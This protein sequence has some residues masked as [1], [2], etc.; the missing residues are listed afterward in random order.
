MNKISNESP[1][2]RQI[3]ITII[4]YLILVAGAIAMLLPFWWMIISSFKSSVELFKMPPTWFPQNFTLENYKKV[5]ELIPFLSYLKNSLAVGIVTTLVGMFTSSLLGYIFAKYEFPGKNIIF[6]SILV[7]LIVPYQMLMIP[8]FKIMLSFGWLDTYKVLTIPYFYNIFGIFLMRQFMRDVPNELME[9]AE[10]DGCS[11]FGTF[12]K[13]VI[14][15]VTPA[16]AT[17]SI[18]L[19]MASWDSF[20]WPLIAINSESLMTLPIG[21]N[22]F[23]TSHGGNYGYLMAASLMTIIPMVL[24]FL[25]SQKKFI[26]GI[27][28]QGVKG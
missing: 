9:A 18:F 8:L 22:S 4:K 12:F 20:M 28:L 14:P 11:N 16:L 17:L 3:V 1:K 25:V 27:A 23:L 24:V 7:C 26:E 19:F 5:F 13:I 2:N 6:I 10:I 15:V 21:L